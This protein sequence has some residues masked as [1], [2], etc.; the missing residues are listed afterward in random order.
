M[1]IGGLGHPSSLWLAVRRA[2]E[3][4]DP[5][6]QE[7]EAITVEALAVAFG[8]H[9]N[10]IFTRARNRRWCRPSWYD[11]RALGPRRPRRAPASELRGKV[12]ALLRQAAC[13]GVPCPSNPAI[14]GALAIAERTARDALTTLRRA[15][16]IAIEHAPSYARRIVFADGSATAWSRVVPP[17][18]PAKR[19]A[20]DVAAPRRAGRAP[21]RRPAGIDLGAAE[22][23]TSLRRRGVHAFDRGVLTGTWRREW[24]IDG[25]VVDRAGLLDQ[26]ARR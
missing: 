18:A 4:R 25:K 2:F 15:G 6:R 13:A 26:A 20:P 11:T 14:A 21:P 5:A 12:L 10:S 3:G 16:T 23:T 22:A 7:R 19:A 24:V 9:V 17:P 8:I 1:K